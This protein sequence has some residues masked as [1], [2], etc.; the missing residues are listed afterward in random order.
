MTPAMITVQPGA[1][2]TSEIRVRNKSNIVDQYEIVVVG[3]PRQWTIIE[4]NLLSLFPDKEGVA[5]VRFSPPRSSEVRAGRKPFDIVVQ[6]KASPDIWRTRKEPSRSAPF[7]TH[8]S[9]S[10]R[11]PAAAVSSPPIDCFFRIRAMRRCRRRSTGRIPTICW[12]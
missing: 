12:R 10:R 9:Q 2:E 8:R 11:A 3:E 1:A 4:P 5:T 7:T 6:S